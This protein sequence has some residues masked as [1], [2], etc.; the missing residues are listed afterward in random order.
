M[1][2]LDS[3]LITALATFVTSLAGLV[4]AFRRY[5]SD[6]RYLIWE[7]QAQQSRRGLWDLQVDQIMAPWEWRAARRNGRRSRAP[8][9]RMFPI[10]N[11]A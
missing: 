1:I 5:L 10:G 9:E 4:W 3:T 11:R 7:R 2:M 6:Q 8:T